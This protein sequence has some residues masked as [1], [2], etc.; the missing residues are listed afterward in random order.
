MELNKLNHLQGLELKKCLICLEAESK[1]LIL[2]AETYKGL[3]GNFSVPSTFL[4]SAEILALTPPDG[5]QTFIVLAASYF[6]PSSY[7]IKYLYSQ[8]NP[9]LVLVKVTIVAW[10][11]CAQLK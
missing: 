6:Q 7:I 8:Y 4:L 3:Y 10:D 11:M 9:M 5:K 2:G 1:L